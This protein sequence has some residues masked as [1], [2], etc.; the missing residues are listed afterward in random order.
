[1]TFDNGILYVVVGGLVSNGESNEVFLA[2]NNVYTVNPVT[3]AY[4]EVG[5]IPVPIFDISSQTP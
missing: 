3:A 1:M 4:S 2:T 5:L